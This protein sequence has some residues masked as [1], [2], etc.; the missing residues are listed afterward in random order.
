MNH[1]EGRTFTTDTTRSDLSGG[2]LVR[3]QPFW[4]TLFLL[5][6]IFAQTGSP[7]WAYEGDHYALTYYLALKV[8]FTQ[9]QAYQIAS[10]AYA[11]DWDANTSPMEASAG[12]AILGAG[13]GSGNRK[14]PNQRGI[15]EALVAVMLG[16][17]D[18][19][20]G[21]ERWKFAGHPGLVP[22]KNPR[23]ANIWKNF[24]AFADDTVLP[25]PSLSE[26]FLLRKPLNIP[27]G[28]NVFIG[29]S[30]TTVE[31]ARAQSIFLQS[32][33]DPASINECA[34]HIKETIEAQRSKRKQELWELAQLDRNPGPLIHYI[35][36]Y[37][38][39]FLYNNTRG[40][41]IAGHASDFLSFSP[42]R[43]QGAT[44]DTLQ[45]LID[46]RDWLG[47]FVDHPP[48]NYLPQKPLSPSDRAIALFLAE[49]IETNPK[50]DIHDRMLFD[51]S[52]P[53]RTVPSLGKSLAVVND[54]MF[55]NRDISWPARLNQSDQE[56]PQKWFD[57][58]YSPQGRFNDEETAQVERVGLRFEEASIKTT[59]ASDPDKIR[60]FVRLP[61]KISGLAPLGEYLYPLPVIEEH[62]FTG[63]P[64]KPFWI[65]YSLGDGVS[66]LT[67]YARTPAEPQPT[68]G[69]DTYAVV[70]GEHDE[71]DDQTSELEPLVARL[72]RE[73]GDHYMEVQLQLSQEDFTAGRLTWEPSVRLYGY[74]AKVGQR[75]VLRPPTEVCSDSTATGDTATQKEA[76]RKTIASVGL[77]PIAHD[78]ALRFANGCSTPSFWA[79]NPAELMAGGAQRSITVWALANAEAARY[80][81][82]CWAGVD[83][84]SY[85]RYG[86]TPPASEPIDLIKGEKAILVPEQGSA[87][88]YFVCGNVLAK[89]TEARGSSTPV[90]EEYQSQREA[91][92][93]KLSAEA[94]KAALNLM[95]K[96]AAALSDQGACQSCP[97]TEPVETT[98][99]Q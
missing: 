24:H 91:E 88:G 37:H 64:L 74:E 1:H 96:L 17:G 83:R 49:M 69:T 51:P 97:P 63:M 55:I 76:I 9:R 27:L 45:R 44:Q 54:S 30:L 94:R 60:V 41:A 16:L 11:L 59:K 95:S 13:A 81:L 31:E 34:S 70:T 86:Q 29:C 35:Q 79:K 72:R 10:G 53:K 8:G 66:S 22:T 39:H 5:F 38:S 3:R 52:G 99:T 98:R 73:N 15:S 36:D 57:Y 56:V 78:P 26:F 90:G 48:E 65:A 6:A 61:Y 67:H 18:A 4:L 12:D 77:E 84:G 87:T 20:V 43:A 75:L 32:D 71:S 85:A 42:A 80:N 25:L 7:V 33:F 23:L 46:F 68:A 28:L 62:R 47:T 50:P 2:M 40:H 14:L 19:T 92:Y 93:V 21:V 89:V 82:D 58:K